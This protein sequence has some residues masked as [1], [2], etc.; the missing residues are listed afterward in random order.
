MRTPGI[1]YHLGHAGLV[2]AVALAT[3]ACTGGPTGTPGASST[4]TTA[5][6]S[7][8]SRRSRPPGADVRVV[9][10]DA[11]ETGRVEALADD[12]PRTCA[13]S[14]SRRARAT[15]RRRRV[16][17]GRS[18]WPP[19]GR[20][21]CSASVSACSRW[22]RPSAARSSGRRPGPRRGVRG[23][24]RRG[25]AAGRDAAVVHGRPLPLARGGSGDP[26]AEL[27]VTAM[28]EVDR[29]VMGIRHVAL[30]LEGVQFHPRVGA[31]AGGPAPA[32]QLPPPRR[33]RRG[34]AL[35]DASGS[36]ATAGWPRRRE[37][38]R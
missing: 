10:N 32:R 31:D 6:R 7:T 5:S 38:V 9:R 24:P 11:I 4:T 21:R 3:A 37:G 12:R 2:L 29:V 35:D 15:R 17:R 13:G 18:R 14:S 25:R 28:S 23:D 8:S 36:F 20:S 30:P 19:I 1:T 16:G 22:R 27:R 34:V 33:G 26:P